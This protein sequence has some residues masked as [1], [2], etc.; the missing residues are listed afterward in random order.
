MRV[1]IEPS[2]ARG[3]VSA[4][5]SKS[6]A[7]RMLICAGLAHKLEPCCIFG[8]E[9]SQDILATIDCLNA[10]GACVNRQDDCAMVYGIDPSVVR[11][12]DVL[13]CRECGSTLR[14][15]VPLC[16][17]LNKPLTLT[18][19]ET[20]MSRPMS[21]YE[22][23]C[24]QQGLTFYHDDQGIHVQGPLHADTFCIPG[25]ISSQ[26]ISGLLFALPLLRENS[27][28][29]LTGTVES[30]PYI[31][32][33]IE[34]LSLFGV[35]VTWENDTTL[36]ILGNQRYKDIT[37]HVEGDYSNAAF[38]EAL[39]YLD[40]A[41]ATAL[42]AATLAF[43]NAGTTYREGCA[44]SERSSIQTPSAAPTRNGNASEQSFVRMSQASGSANVQ[45]H[46]LRESSL[47]GDAAYQRLFPA[48]ASGT[49]TISLAN[50]PD[51]GPILMA[52]AAANNGAT[53]TNCARLA[54]KESN[55]GEA[56][57]QELA[58][59]GATTTI[60]AD[61][62]TIVVAPGMFHTPYQPLCGH[63]DHRIVMALATLASAVGGTIED[64]QAV[65]KSFPSYF[66]H[67]AQLG[68]TLHTEE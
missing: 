53:F 60:S 5:P 6:M 43:L 26:F 68:V 27:R 64:A 13:P 3:V 59:F 18:G 44:A 14:F 49:P 20:L 67:L 47:Q 58:K 4:P 9:D 15:F 36:T 35:A 61:N 52:V 46:G 50:C 66:E 24:R 51:L 63:N 57:A 48:L 39:N 12:G 1:T 34:A 38:L 32:M 42:P 17:L 31:D 37:V 65:Q 29:E 23:I 21:V 11:A 33:T 25:N 16:L 10:L 28:I 55:R 45:V 22:D 7:H 19:S 30:R 41:R 2:I 54:I 40:K 62:N 56:M 8:L